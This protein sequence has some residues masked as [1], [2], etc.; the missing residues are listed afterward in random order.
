MLQYSPGQL[1][2]S[3]I[4]RMYKSKIIHMY[5]MEPA[6]GKTIKL[7]KTMKQS[8]SN[9]AKISRVLAATMIACQIGVAAKA[10]VTPVYSVQSP[11]AANLGMYGRVPVSPYTGIPEISVPIYELT[12]GRMRVPVSLSYHLASVKPNQYPGSVGLGWSL[13]CGGCISRTVRGI[14]DE[15][16]FLSNGVTYYPGFYAHC[17]EMADIT[18]GSFSEKTQNHLMAERGQDYY[19]LSADEFSFNFCGYSG[20][21]YLNEN[22]E[23]T[24]VSDQ[25]IKVVFNPSTGFGTLNELSGR[26]SGVDSWSNRNNN[27]RFFKEFTIITP[28]GVRYVFGGT[29]A[30]DFSVPY[31]NR[32]S[33][34]L[35]ASS[36]YLREI[37]TTDNHV[38]TFNYTA[39][40]LMVDIRYVPGEKYTVGIEASDNAY[41]YSKET[42]R[43]AF[44]G[45]L[46]FPV[47]LVS[48][49]SPSE[50]V[51]FDYVADWHYGDAYFQSGAGCLYWSD[52]N[53]SHPDVYSGLIDNPAAQFHE[54]MPTFFGTS[55]RQV[56]RS[57]A[58]KLIAKYLHRIAITAGSSSH[59]VYL[60]YQEGTRRK[61]KGVHWRDGVDDIDISYVIGDGVAY[62][63][64][65]I[66]DKTSD[67]WPDYNFTYNA[68][69]MPHGY[70]LPQ[71]D[72]WGY[73]N[74]HSHLLS[75][76]YIQP[77]QRSLLATEYETL[78]EIMYP[79]GCRRR[80][81]YEG[82]DYSKY[83]QQNHI[84]DED[85][86]GVSGGLRVKTITDLTCEGEIVSQKNYLYRNG[87]SRC[88]EPS[89]LAYECN[90]GLGA[91]VSLNLR[92][93][94]GF[95]S[96]STN[97][98]TPDVGYSTVCEQTMDKEGNC[99]GSV[100]YQ[101]SNYDT[102]I[103]GMSH[104]D[105]CAFASYN[106]SSDGPSCPYSSNSAERGKLL[107]K[108]WLTSTGEELRK[109]T[110]RYARVRN[111]ALTTAT[112]RMVYFC[113]DPFNSI[114]APVGW[115]THTYT[116]AYMPVEVN[117]TE[118]GHTRCTSMSYNDSFL[119]TTEIETLSDGG[120]RMR[121]LTYPCDHG[122]SLSW[123]IDNHIISSVISEC[124]IQ[125]NQSRTR[126][127]DY[128]NAAAFRSARPVP[129]V[130]KVE[131]KT[132]MAPDYRTLYEVVS[133]DSFG[134]PTEIIEDGVHSILTWGMSGQRLT[135]RI[136]NMTL[137]EY[138]SA[139]LLPDLSEGEAD[140]RMTWS[141][142]Y[143]NLLLTRETSPDGI[144][145]YY[146]YDPLGRLI[147]TYYSP[148][149]E[150]PFQ[151][152]TIST[153]E[154]HYLTTEQR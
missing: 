67:E 130:S 90:I 141:Y 62:P 34:D 146:E 24:V 104:C 93:M 128:G 75:S 105:E 132:D 15:K 119:K 83:E 89:S 95:G 153:N 37:H 152:C 21:F 70:V 41:L 144:S 54:L 82:R 110:Y 106:I 147:E 102:D 71:V 73:Y 91:R 148:N 111:G 112:Q 45:F 20:N 48:V 2:L 23:W 43:N 25:D 117:I 97:I 4:G 118:D 122:D 53:Y 120:T 56:N 127:Y 6:Y 52:T 72:S 88:V 78:E 92:S 65:N 28:D 142:G 125:N 18:A 131:C 143:D 46:L 5:G 85:M 9:L 145:T 60:S 133:T 40:E 59:S 81:K 79:T 108:T 123:M 13:N 35:V 17:T 80:F 11:D 126:K 66:P 77:P 101:Y 149:F 134:N 100:V 31:Y 76:N 84:I 154:Y 22:N 30:I 150:L 121:L 51:R 36:W 94:Y 87:I 137:E 68:G 115:L 42:G 98:N 44:T 26:I 1:L 57:I 74:G 58:N 16:S 138:R 135:K 47:K 19:E 136:W 27:R 7:I 109:E 61:L 69:Q 8:R 64:Y 33:G 86:H 38:V 29:N 114:T 10:E 113:L 12:A 151:R 63:F 14:Y 55:D 3:A 99:L 140:G 129:Y 124:E 32:K 103:N 96:S 116:Y 49:V 50:T 139:P 107:S 39:T